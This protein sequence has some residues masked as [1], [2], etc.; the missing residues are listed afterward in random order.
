[1]RAALELRVQAPN[2]SRA[3]QKH[4]RDWPHQPL[5]SSWKK[6]CK[7]SCQLIKTFDSLPLL[8]RK[9]IVGRI[10][11]KRN[12]IQIE[13]P[14]GAEMTSDEMMF[15]QKHR[16]QVN[17]NTSK[18]TLCYLPNSWLSGNFS[19]PPIITR[20]QQEDIRRHSSSLQGSEAV[21]GG[22]RFAKLL[23]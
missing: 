13:P 17:R 7:G 16:H 8:I 9:T 22:S 23:D 12:W 15:F 1:M 10:T 4:L 14:K 21:L 11:G 5:N 18:K 2:K 3:F 19:Q 20:K 6:L